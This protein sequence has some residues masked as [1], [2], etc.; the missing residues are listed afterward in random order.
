VMGDWPSPQQTQPI[1]YARRGAPPV[2]LLTGDADTTVRPRNSIN[3]HRAMEDAGAICAVKAY[4]GLN[5]IDPIMAISRPFRAKA[6]VM[7]DASAF[8]RT[9]PE[10]VAAQQPGR[11]NPAQK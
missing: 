8:I 7:D 1:T 9:A 5:H 3:L 6:P 2:L 10:S 4:A 11:E